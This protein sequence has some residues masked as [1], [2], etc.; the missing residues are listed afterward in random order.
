MHNKTYYA[1]IHLRFYTLLLQNC[2]Y[3]V[4]GVITSDTQMTV[5]VFFDK[6]RLSP[7][8]DPKTLNHLFNLKADL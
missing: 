2:I 1:A 7:H 6:S 5:V 4:S 8:I 3:P